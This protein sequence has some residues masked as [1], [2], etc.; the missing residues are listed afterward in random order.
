MTASSQNKEAEQFK[1]VKNKQ[2]VE[3]LEKSFEN[4]KSDILRIKFNQW[5]Q[6]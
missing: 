2:K 6:N 3:N 4:L 5:R 1:N